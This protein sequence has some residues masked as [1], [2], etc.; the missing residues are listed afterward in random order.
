MGLVF[1]S[2][3]AWYFCGALMVGES[4][5]LSPRVKRELPQS[6]AARIFLTWLAPGPATGYVFVLA[7]ML[8]IT[9]VAPVL[10]SDWFRELVRS[11][12]VVDGARPS[13]YASPIRVLEASVIATSYLGIYLGLGKLILAAVRRYDETRLSLRVLVHLLLGLAG[14]GIPWVIQITYP[15]TRNLGYTLLQITN[16]VWTLWECC[17]RGGLPPTGAALMLVLPLAALLVGL[18]NMP[19]LLA[20]LRQ[21]RISKPPRVAEEDRALAAARAPEPARS[22]P[23]DG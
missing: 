15:P 14:G 17:A 20:E 1:L 5:V 23:W 16:P 6:W 2:A 19:S 22:S 13:S 3:C 4:P 8:M 18:L 7:I 21:V 9:L 11:L 12:G 10:A